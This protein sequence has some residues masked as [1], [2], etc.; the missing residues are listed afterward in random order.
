MNRDHMNYEEREAMRILDLVRS[1]AD[2]PYS[3]V[4]WALRVTGDALGLRDA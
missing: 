1:G 4:M 3:T 2:V